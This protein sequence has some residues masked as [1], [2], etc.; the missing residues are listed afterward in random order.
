MFTKSDA[1][2]VVISLIGSVGSV[3]LVYREMV[4]GILCPRF[5][6]VPACVLVLIAYLMVLGSYMAFRKLLYGIGTF[7][8]LLIAIWFSINQFTKS[9]I[10]PAYLSIPLCY[11]SLA[12][13]VII[14]ILGLLRKE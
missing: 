14:F 4:Y 13:F 7:M 10:C 9:I 5:M 3:L 8:G 6:G 1:A 11:A 12:A 2:I